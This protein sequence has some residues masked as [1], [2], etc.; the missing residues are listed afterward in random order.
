[1][2]I[3]RC[4]LPAGKTAD[5]G[6]LKPN[7]A[8]IEPINGGGQDSLTASPNCASQAWHKHDTSEAALGAWG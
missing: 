8:I 4:A 5:Q 6:C 2:A 1:M 3:F 7:I